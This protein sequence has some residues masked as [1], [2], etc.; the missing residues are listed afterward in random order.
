MISLFSCVGK[1]LLIVTT[2]QTRA[3]KHLKSHAN[4]PLQIETASVGCFSEDLAEVLRVEFD[5]M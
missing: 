2:S 1:I 5:G 3:R 4:N